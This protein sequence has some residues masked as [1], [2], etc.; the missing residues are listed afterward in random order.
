[1]NGKKQALSAIGAL[2]EA[3]EIPCVTLARAVHVD[4]SLVSKW[5]S[6]ERRPGPDSA[7]FAQINDF[8][9]EPERRSRLKAALRTFYP[10]DKLDSDGEIKERLESFLCGFDD[11]GNVRGDAPD[12]CGSVSVR[13]FEHSAG[14]RD[15]VSTLL[16]AAEAMDTPGC[17]YCVD[18]E[19]YEWLLEDAEYAAQWVKRMLALLD[20]GSTAHFVVHFRPGADPFLRFFNVCGSLL[21]HRNMKWYR[22]RYYDDENYWFSFFTL[23]NAISVMGMAMDGQHSYTTLFRDRLSVMNHRA[24]VNAVIKGCEPFFEDFGA[25]RCAEAAARLENAASGGRLWVYLP[26]PALVCSRSEIIDRILKGCGETE[27]E[28]AKIKTLAARF[29]RAL[30]KAS[31]E[32]GVH[33]G[34]VRLIFQYDRMIGCISD[35][36]LSCSLSLFAQRPVRAPLNDIAAAFEELAGRLESASYGSAALTTEQDFS[37]I[38]EMNCWCLE[39]KWLIQMDR[40]GFRFCDE[41]VIVS[42]ATVVL[43]KAWRKIPPQRKDMSAAVMV[44]ELARDIAASAQSEERPSDTQ[45]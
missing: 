38:S 37:Q 25:D 45:Q 39:D 13:I 3:M 9:V 43:E 41:A 30:K 15:A 27:P 24:V 36:F 35:P 6:G 42:A 18:A 5:K 7:Y 31:P 14:R 16:S 44:R 8:F 34:G 12:E 1:M 21:F 19:Q 26:V 11:A 29:K 2:L 20:R 23:E 4:A 32:D 28:R 10:Q 40:S 22:H 33:R 17:I